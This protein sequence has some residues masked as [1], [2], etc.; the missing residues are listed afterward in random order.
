MCKEMPIGQE[1]SL[2]LSS[3]RPKAPATSVEYAN[4]MQRSFSPAAIWQIAFR[5]FYHTAHRLVISA[6]ERRHIVRYAIEANE[7]IQHVGV[8]R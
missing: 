4:S 7:L 5:I 6:V 2:P 3:R 1:G 8:G